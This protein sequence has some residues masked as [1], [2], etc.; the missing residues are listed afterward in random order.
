MQLPPCLSSGYAGESLGWIAL[1]A[2]PFN[3]QSLPGYSGLDFSLPVALP[4]SSLGLLFFFL[5]SGQPQDIHR[6]WMKVCRCL[7]LVDGLP[8][9]L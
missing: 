2:G 4:C 9:L 3:L 1:A 8:G 7:G 5:A 6:N